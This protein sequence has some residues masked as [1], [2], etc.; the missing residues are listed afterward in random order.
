VPVLFGLGHD[1]AQARPE[2]ALLLRLLD[3]RYLRVLGGLVL[4]GL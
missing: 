4:E 2:V 3:E 1:E